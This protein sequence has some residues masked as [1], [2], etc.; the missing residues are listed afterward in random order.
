M[1]AYAVF[2]DIDGTLLGRNGIPEENINEIKRVQGLGHQVF[3]CT[4]RS[5]AYL[6]EKLLDTVRPDGMV[7]GLGSYVECHGEVLQSV[8]LPRPVLERVA[9][10]FLAEGVFCV[11]EGET[12]FFSVCDPEHRDWDIQS[13]EE[14]RTR[15]PAERVSKVTVMRVL[16]EADRKVLLP[17]IPV[18]QHPTYAEGTT[19][20]F[21]KSTGIEAALRHLGIPRERSIG[22]GDS[23]NDLEMLSFV[24][25][26]VAM[27]NADERVKS[28]CDMV[29]DTA[30]NG[31]VAKALQRIFPPSAVAL[32]SL[33]L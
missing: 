14:L 17:D 9:A 20:G 6:P 19:A 27:G 13:M 1:E 24:G 11:F 29:T 25:T 26:S 22:M 10:H 4:G 3:L 8:A 18:I 23:A 12:R 15:F 28:A 21:T 31:G 2:L 5:K 32:F 30:E 16:T 33:D 7:G